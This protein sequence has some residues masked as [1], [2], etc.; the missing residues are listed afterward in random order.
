MHDSL[1]PDVSLGTHFFHELVET[2]ILY[3]AVFPGR[4]GNVLKAE[5]FE[6]MR[7]L[8]PDVLP[9]AVR[10][11]DVLRLLAAPG[12]DGHTLKLNADAPRQRAVCYLEGDSDLPAA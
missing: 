3:L 4:D 9:G 8:L 6:G 11:A 12:W 2:D 7:N 10:W 5:F 1:I